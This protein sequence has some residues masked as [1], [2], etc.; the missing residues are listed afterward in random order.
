MS[1]KLLLLAA[2]AAGSGCHLTAGPS[3]P[4]AHAP[5]YI[6][7]A[8]ETVPVPFR[9]VS[10]ID[11]QGYSALREHCWFAKQRRLPRRP[12]PGCNTPKRY[13]A[14]TTEGMGRRTA[15]R[16]LANGWDRR[17]LG[18][19]IDLFVLHYDVCSSSRRCFEVLH[20]VRGLS[21]HFLLDLDGTLY[22]TLDLSLRARHAGSV[23]NRSIGIEIAHIGA[24]T[25]GEV[26]GRFYH[27]GAD[28]YVWLEVPKEYGPPPGGPFR[29]ARPGLIRGKIH[30]QELIMPDYT[31]AQYATLRALTKSLSGIFPR[32]RRRAPRDADGTVRSTVLAPERLAAFNGVVGH[33]HLTRS[34]IDPGPA[35][36]WDRILK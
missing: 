19:R 17:S 18:E 31:E 36:D 9:V 2:L 12:A 33:Y 10:F 15:A 5:A 7:V 24:Y 27:P 32:V 23:N 26:L 35:L 6:I 8:G 13:G 4:P 11:A 1:V 16:V 3:E 28:G 20:D 14:R 21:C 30:G 25:D 22:Q 34:K 29:P